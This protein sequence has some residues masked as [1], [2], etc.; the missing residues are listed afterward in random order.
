MALGERRYLGIAVAIPLFAWS[1]ALASE[2]E[3]YVFFVLHLGY[4]PAHGQHS[5]LLRGRA[6]P[7][8]GLRP[9]LHGSLLDRFS[10]FHPS[11][12][13]LPQ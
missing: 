3:Y 12:L 6:S 8:V 5:R 1:I 11:A 2:L 13:R 9:H 4:F 10:G 7:V